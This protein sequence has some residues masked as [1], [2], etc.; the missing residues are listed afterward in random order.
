MLLGIIHD[1]VRV[2][3][4]VQSISSKNRYSIGLRDTVILTKPMYE[5][6]V[7]SVAATSLMSETCDALLSVANQQY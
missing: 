2:S 7:V 3:D 6:Q 1:L 5:I 4:Q